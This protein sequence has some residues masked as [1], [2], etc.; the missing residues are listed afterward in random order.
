MSNMNYA[1]YPVVILCGGKGTRIREET[2]NKPKPM[3]E[4]GNRPI[5]WHIMKTYAQY[6]FNNFV[7]CLGY[8]GEVIKSYFLNY[9]A[10]NSDFSLEGRNVRLLSE[11]AESNWTVALASTGL[12]AM[13]GARIK[14][15]ERYVETDNFLVTY[16][17]G[18]ADIDI[19]EL[20]KFHH[21]HG[22][23]GTVTGVRYSS[24]FGE[25]TTTEDRVIAFDE[26]PA[27]V[28][29]ISGGFFV[30]KKEMFKYLQN[31]D[32][33]VLEKEP[34]EKLA[35]EGELMVYKHRG[36]WQ[37]LDTFRDKQLLNDMWDSGDA[38]W[39]TWA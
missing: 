8:K 19:E 20:L 3:V 2:D 24:R 13:T 22:K 29:W 12:E 5:L 21:S 36:F 7:L 16:G 31:Q 4:I 35:A 30:F 26:K 14:R 28:G 25:L 33:C 15:I 17:D 27:K 23:I 9:K 37:C 18:V 34:L 1:N 32:S 39:K 6:D 11:C 10:L 38:K